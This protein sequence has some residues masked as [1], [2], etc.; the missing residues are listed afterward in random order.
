M[1]YSEKYLIEENHSDGTNWVWE[2]VPPEGDSS[3]DGYTV[4]ETYN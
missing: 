4:D 2:R 1:D 3:Y